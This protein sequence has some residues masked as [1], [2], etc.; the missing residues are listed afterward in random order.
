VKW[1]GKSG[2]N[3]HADFV[4]QTDD[5][6]GQVVKALRDNDMLDNTLVICSSDNGTSAPTSKKSKLE[7]MGH[8]PSGDLRGS[9]ADI[10]DGGHRVP[11][12]VHWP[13]VI[14]AD[15]SSDK[16]VCLT[17]V[18]ATAA[19]ITD[20]K[21]PP[22]AGEDSI[23]FLPV[24]KGKQSH[25]RTSVIHHSI[26]G[27]FAIRDGKYKLMMCPGSGGWTKPKPSATLWKQ[28]EEQGK[29]TVQ[30]YDMSKDI[31]EHENLAASMPEKVKSIAALLKKQVDDGRT[32][33]GP[34]QA[35]DAP[36]DIDKR[37]GGKKRKG[38][39]KHKKN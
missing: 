10:W 28:A 32:T 34:K 4:M 16:L 20:F 15:T 6:Y 13:K 11:F 29:P 24:L 1:Q 17:D 25:A 18:M 5:S 33:P 3:A 2:L 23:S 12:I 39:N 31:G 7:K 36:V 37:S 27:H 19:Q 35:N 14:K 8:F 38:K 21:L 9:K 26:S 22:N 30:L